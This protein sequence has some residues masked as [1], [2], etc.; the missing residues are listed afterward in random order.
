MATY[1]VWLRL[2][3]EYDDIEADSEEEA[4]LIASDAAI[5]GGSWEYFV[6]EVEVDNG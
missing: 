5:G 4:F 1:K 2:E 6:E 3:C